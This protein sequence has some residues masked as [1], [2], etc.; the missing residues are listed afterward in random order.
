MKL[1]QI[2]EEITE[3]PKAKMQWKLYWRNVVR[4]YHVM[5]E[6]WPEKYPFKNLSDVTS[7]LVDLEDL[8]RKWQCGTIHWRKLS[9]AEFTQMDLHRD[10][11]I[12][13]GTIVDPAI[14]RRRSDCGQKRRRNMDPSLLHPSKKPR[15]RSHVS[16]DDD[17][18]AGEHGQDPPAVD[19]SPAR[20]STAAAVGS[21]EGID[22]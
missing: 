3:D 21:T 20:G 16:D 5:V 15:S 11:N 12:E 4:R 9:V 6:G 8:L 14:R 13:N 19:N 22:G 2:L 1:T 17:D 7:S 18:S 10:Q